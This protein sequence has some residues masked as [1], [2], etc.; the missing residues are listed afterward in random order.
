MQTALPLSIACLA[1]SLRKSNIEVKV[2]DTVLYQE[3]GEIDENEERAEHHH[4]TKQLN[5]SSV[6]LEKKTHD[7]LQDFEQAVLAYQPDLIGISTVESTFGRGMRLAARAK[8]VSA[9][10]IVVGGVF[11]TLAPEIAI[12]D[13]SVNMICIGEGED[14]LVELCGSL[15]NGIDYRA[16]MNLWIKDNGTIIK[17]PLR[18]LC[19]LDDLHEP[20]FSVFQT[21]MFY[22]PMQGNLFK[23]IP[24]ELS[25]GC[26]Y[27]CSYCAEPSLKRLYRSHNQAYFRKKSIPQL[28][29]EIRHAIDLYAPEFFYFATETFLAMSE[30]EFDEFIEQYRKIKI[31]FWIQTRPETVTLKRITA[32]QEVGMFWITMGIECG[33]EEFR[34]LH[35]K[36]SMSNERIKESVM[37]LE[38]SGQ[39]ASLNSIIGFPH[40]TRELMFE[41]IMLNRELFRINPRIRA[42]ISV[43]TPFRGCE[44]YDEGV[45]AGLFSPVAYLDQTNISSSVLRFNTLSDEEFAGICRT[46]PL[47]VYLPD[48]DADLISIAEAFDELGN[49]T[50]ESLNR[51]L[52]TLLA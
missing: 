33:N 12:A 17:N 9:A 20:D 1:A 36:R 27:N 23:T 3:T 39:G 44:L 10:P 19:S 11:P 40:E 37:I 42:N 50:Y 29:N 51:K 46:V 15:K 24:I 18:P 38:Q 16:I 48:E 35:L 4:S 31:P 47:H 6:G 25:R 41:T 32:L 26:P 30:E 14:A 43:F 22:K 45:K 5:Y 28:F 49:K 13:P 52:K 7:L 34:R 21:H 2:F 8:S